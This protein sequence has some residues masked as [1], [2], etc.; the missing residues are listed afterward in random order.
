MWS[1]KRF[2]AGAVDV[3]ANIAALTISHDCTQDKKA[4]EKDKE[5]ERDKTKPKKEAKDSRGQP[6][7]NL[8]G[9]VAQKLEPLKGDEN[10]T[11]C[12]TVAVRIL[13]KVR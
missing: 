7:L 10:V 2:R 3:M 6:M 8:A 4:K 13:D 12:Y 11:G 5:R 1:A 9:A